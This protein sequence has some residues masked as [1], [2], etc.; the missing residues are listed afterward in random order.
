MCVCVYVFCFFTCVCHTRPLLASRRAHRCLFVA[1]ATVSSLVLPIHHAELRPREWTLS[2]PQHICMCKQSCTL[3]TR[4]TPRSLGQQLYPIKMY[5]RKE[6]PIDF[7]ED[8]SMLHSNTV[9]PLN[10]INSNTKWRKDPPP[11]HSSSS[12]SFHSV[13]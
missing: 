6:E 4:T 10:A 3:Y 7:S 12:S 11:M 13:S 8:A 5:T 1:T 2:P 9:D